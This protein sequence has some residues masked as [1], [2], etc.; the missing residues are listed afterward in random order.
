VGA[1]LNACN[2]SGVEGYWDRT[3]AKV[4]QKSIFHPRITPKTTPKSTWA[5]VGQGWGMCQCR[6]Y[7]SY[8]ENPPGPPQKILV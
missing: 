5:K 6:S 1:G 3:G 7:L 8:H 4:G 2:R